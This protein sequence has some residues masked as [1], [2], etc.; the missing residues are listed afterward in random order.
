MT[1]YLYK[2]THNKT[3]FKYLGK[4]VKNPFQYQG[5]GKLWLPHLKKHGYDITTEII[6]ECATK[7]EIRYWGKHYSKLWNIVDERDERGK[8]TWANLK[9]EEGD[10]GDNSEFIDYSYT[11]ESTKK[12]AATCRSLGIGIYG[13]TKEDLSKNGK[14]GAAK[15]KEMG[16]KPNPETS[17]TNGM[18]AA[19]QVIIDGVSY[20]SLKQ[21]AA[22]LNI[23]PETLGWRCRSN[24]FP[25]YQYLT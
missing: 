3:G 9:P 11:V 13:M 20:P 2:K 5:S 4:T 10:G 6:K 24:N 21:A 16:W 18:R 1:I 15:A 23:L 22:A 8:K 12:T 25:N 19:R 14:K 7:E 17:R